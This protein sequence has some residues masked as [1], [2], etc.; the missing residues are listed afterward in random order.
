MSA[1]GDQRWN[2][3]EWARLHGIA[4]AAGGGSEYEEAAFYN[5]AYVNQTWGIEGGLALNNAGRMPGYAWYGLSPYMTHAAPKWHTTVTQGHFRNGR[6]YSGESLVQD[7][8][9]V[10]SFGHGGPDMGWGPWEERLFANSSHAKRFGLLSNFSVP[11]PG[12]EYVI[13]I[14]QFPP[15]CGSIY[16]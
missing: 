11:T 8:C 10:M 12:N 7:N 2:V 14:P 1:G 9:D 13:Q 6:A 5:K 3:R 16:E 15:D 4:V